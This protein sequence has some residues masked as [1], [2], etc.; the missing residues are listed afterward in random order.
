MNQKEIS[1]V[2]NYSSIFVD[3]SRSIQNANTDLLVNACDVSR[4]CGKTVLC[5]HKHAA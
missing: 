5:K 2:E 3:V 1:E 4:S